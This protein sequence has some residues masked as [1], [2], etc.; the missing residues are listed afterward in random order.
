[1]TATTT[2][3]AG[4]GAEDA[5]GRP[6]PDPAELWDQ[7]PPPAYDG[8]REAA[9]AWHQRA[10]EHHAS[11]GRP[12]PWFPVPVIP[13]RVPA[14]ECFPMGKGDAKVAKDIAHKQPARWLSDPGAAAAGDPHTIKARALAWKAKD[15]SLAEV[16]EAIDYA[17]A[18]GLAI[19]LGLVFP[20]GGD[21]AAVDVDRK[22][23]PAGGEGDAAFAADIAALR[24]WAQDH[25]CYVETTPGGGVHVVGVR[26]AGA[27]P[28]PGKFGCSGSAIDGGGEIR[29]GGSNGFLVVAP[30]HRAGKAEPYASAMAPAVGALPADLEAMGLC[31]AADRPRQAPEPPR[32]APAAGPKPSSNGNGREPPPRPYEELERIVSSYPTI[33]KK[34]RQ[35]DEALKFVCGL[36]RCMEAIGKGKQDAIALASRHHP[37]A[38]DTFEQVE[39]WPFEQHSVDSFIAQCKA[40]RVDVTR[41]DLKGKRPPIE[42]TPDQQFDRPTGNGNGRDPT[43][44]ED[45]EGRVFLPYPELLALALDA[46]AEDDLGAEV[47]LRAEIM[48]RFK[49]TDAQITADLFKLLTARESGGKQHKVDRSKGVDLQKVN[50]LEFAVD[51]FVPA[52]DQ[53]ILDATSGAGKTLAAIALAFAVIDGTGFLDRSAATASGDVLFIA[54]D[55]GSSPFRLAMEHLGYLEHP[56]AASDHPG[57]GSPRLVVWAHEEEQGQEAWEASLRGCLQLLET[58]KAGNFRLVVIDSCKA[59]TSMAGLD[60]CNN[61]QVTCLLTF[62]KK[63]ICP[64][65]AVLWIN[66]N[67]TE[68]GATAGA[69]AWREVPSV[70]HSIEKVVEERDEFGQF[71][72]KVERQDVRRWIC[73]KSRLGGERSF[74]Y[75]FDRDKGELRIEPEVVVVGDCREAVLSVLRAALERGETSL[76]RQEVVKQVYELHRAPQGTVDNTLG[77]ITAGKHPDVVKPRRGRYALAPRLAQA[78]ASPRDQQVGEG[79]GTPPT[80]PLNY[81]PPSREEIPETQ[82]RERD[83]EVHVNFTREKLTSPKARQDQSLSKTEEFTCELDVNSTFASPQQGSGQFHSHGEAPLKGDL[84]LDPPWLTDLLAIRAAAPES[85]P[86]TLVLSLSPHWGAITGR[87]AAEALAAWDA[88]QPP[89]AP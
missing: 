57:D 79:A 24:Q 87:Q 60:Y 1:V 17:E 50:G 14:A 61:T 19:G 7:C 10:A 11:T 23:W 65:T 82:D 44:T 51:G 81:A 85:H 56:A 26:P 29:G 22:H 72:K 39:E 3:P 37:E 52:N 27:M 78:V 76:S 73:R 77:R 40:A 74:L 36:A 86:A 2:S 58:V 63:V 67:G 32:P 4:P 64:H 9:R 70:T 54:S 68:K 15:H 12:M 47:R 33:R 83:L 30:T 25:G 42:I 45:P 35:R 66:H 13:G 18:E 43:V 84:A 38:A 69:K 75:G 34:Q 21:G 55:S 28:W 80:T 5:S 16:I 48:G 20:A 31:P 71:T 53:A 59:V 62:F 49:R 89:E 41:H 88:R 6:Q 8:L 46:A